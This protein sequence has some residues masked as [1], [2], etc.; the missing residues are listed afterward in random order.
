MLGLIIGLGIWLV[1][2][3]SIL[4][5]LRYSSKTRAKAYDLIG[6]IAYQKKDEF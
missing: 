4:L 6:R 5:A 3:L 1:A 2:D